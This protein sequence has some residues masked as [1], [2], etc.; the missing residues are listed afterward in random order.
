MVF[1]NNRQYTN[2]RNRP[3]LL[4]LKW[5]TKRAKYCTEDFCTVLENLAAATSRS[6]GYYWHINGSEK[7]PESLHHFLGV[8][9]ESF[10]GVLCSI[11]MRKGSA[12]S[13]SMIE[14]FVKDIG[15][16]PFAE[17]T[18]YTYHFL[19]EEGKRRKQKRHYLRLGSLDSS[20]I[21]VGNQ[22]NV[23]DGIVVSMS[24]E[25]TSR[26][27]PRLTTEERAFLRRFSHTKNVLQDDDDKIDNNKN[28]KEE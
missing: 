2:R 1:V 10:N 6:G 16:K 9:H 27:I 23:S 4:N 24:E 3:P 20:I 21:K 12:T 17:S 7:D 15:G 8:T 25:P 14:K 19:D 5:V 28:N 26:H 18:P 22:Y 13:P 11:G